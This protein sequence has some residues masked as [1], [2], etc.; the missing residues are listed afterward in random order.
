MGFQ[1]FLNGA[2]QLNG[3]CLEDEYLKSLFE[4]GYL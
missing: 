2:C 1:L 3:K 4:V